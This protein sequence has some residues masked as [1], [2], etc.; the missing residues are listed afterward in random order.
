MKK[1]KNIAYIILFITFVLVSAIAFLMPTEKNTNFFIAYGFV[2]LSFFFQPIIWNKAFGENDRLKQQFLGLS[3]VQIGV[4]Y[5][6]MQLIAFAIFVSVA[7]IPTWIVTCICLCIAGFHII[8]IISANFGKQKVSEIETKVSKK[9]M[10]LQEIGV[11]VELLREKE[12]D[13]EMKPL[14]KEIVEKIK[15]SDPMSHEALLDVETRIKEKIDQYKN[16]EDKKAIIQE[17][18]QLLSERNKKCR[19]YKEEK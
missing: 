14:L 19:I 6:V 5:L 9:V 12:T 1:N 16:T 15:Y 2:A 8:F 11:S 10:Y 3:L 17:I 13:A 7:T 18:E 4:M